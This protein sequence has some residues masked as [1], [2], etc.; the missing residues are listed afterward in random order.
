M[1]YTPDAP[2]RLALS[3]PPA[4]RQLIILL[5]GAGARPADLLG[6]AASFHAQW[7]EAAI[8]VPAGQPVDD[9][10]RG[11]Y[12]WYSTHGLSE[13]NRPDRVMAALP[14][15]TGMIRSIQETTRVPPVDTVLAGFSQ[16]AIMALEA[17]AAHD[18]LAGRIIAFAG[19]Y[20]RLPAAA[21]RHSSISLYHG[22]LDEV[23][24]VQH[25]QAAFDH[26]HELGGDVTLDIAHD[27]GHE[28]HPVL[29]AEALD[30]L[31]GQIPARLWRQALAAY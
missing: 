4:P 15:F 11:H 23:I 26:L 25:A 6:L 30:R 12:Q 17:V 21:P 14:V 28:I 31:G 1:Y 27:V 2:G 24:P 3:P 29:V 8:A 10:T 20:A 18:G 9:G 22:D 13:S 5:H 7:P 19:R 16:G